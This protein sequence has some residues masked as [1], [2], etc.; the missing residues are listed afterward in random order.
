MLSTAGIGDLDALF[1][2]ASV[3]VILRGFTEADYVAALQAL[4]AMRAA[5]ELRAQCRQV[6][7]TEFDLERV[8]G[9]RYR[10]LYQRLLAPANV[11]T[12]ETG[13]TATERTTD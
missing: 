12:P 7:V 3:G 4:D 11:L 10:R 8:G 1:A 2:R 5:P 13:Q 9:M 6:A